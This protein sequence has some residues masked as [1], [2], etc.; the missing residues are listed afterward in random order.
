MISTKE[1]KLILTVYKIWRL[2]EKILLFYEASISVIPKPGKDITR[3]ASYRLIFMNIHENYYQN[4]GKT[5]PPIFTK[6]K[7]MTKRVSFGE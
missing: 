7:F 5:L 4:I 1:L 3:K 6:N 2:E